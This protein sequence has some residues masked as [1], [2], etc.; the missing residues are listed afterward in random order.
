MRKVNRYDLFVDICDGNCD[1]M[2]APED[3]EYVLYADYEELEATLERVRAL[4][5]QWRIHADT[6]IPLGSPTHGMEHDLADELE[7]ALKGESDE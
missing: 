4:P 7:Q 2:N 5:Y 3:G 1:V 6:K